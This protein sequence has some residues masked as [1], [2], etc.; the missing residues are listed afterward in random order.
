[1]RKEHHPE[2]A[3]RKVRRFLWLPLT[4][5]NWRGLYERRWL[6][7]AEWEESW[8]DESFWYPTGEWLK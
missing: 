2:G 6:E 4:L 8:V 1:M 7:V 5:R 3:K